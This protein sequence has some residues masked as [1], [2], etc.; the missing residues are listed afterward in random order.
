MIQD[1][2]KLFNQ[3]R[4]HNLLKTNDYIFEVDFDSENIKTSSKIGS[5]DENLN[6]LKD[7]LPPSFIYFIE[8]ISNGLEISIG[9]TLRIYPVDK[10]FRNYWNNI[11]ALDQ[12]VIKG[13]AFPSKDFQ[14][15]GGDGSGQLFAFYTATRF[16]N[17]EFPI[18]RFTP[19]L[20]DTNPFVLLNSS[21]DF[22]LTIQYYLLKATEF[23]K[24]GYLNDEILKSTT[25]LNTIKQDEINWQKF[26]D[27]LYDNF[28]KLIPKPNAD[29]F[30]SMMTLDEIIVAVEQIKNNSC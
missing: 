29:Y 7:N 5:D 11:L 14:F 19:G 6:L 4:T 17:G 22:F 2:N 25:Y 8:K 15:F 16:S 30:Q 27:K 12:W 28:E 10:D 13:K 9:N 24:T 1:I 20:I 23:E 21:F 3:V 18:L 26:H